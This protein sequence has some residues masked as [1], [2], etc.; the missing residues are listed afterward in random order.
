[1]FIFQVGYITAAS[2]LQKYTAGFL[3][4][5]DKKKKGAITLNFP[6]S[7]KRILK[8]ICG[9]ILDVDEQTC[10]LIR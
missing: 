2:N 6:H 1:M 3:Q 10:E 5:M 8:V 7:R 9:G 4:Y